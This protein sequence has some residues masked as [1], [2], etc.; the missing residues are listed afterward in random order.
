MANLQLWIHVP[1]FHASHFVTQQQLLLTVVN[2]KHKQRFPW[3]RH[4]D[5]RFRLVNTPSRAT[6][7]TYSCVPREIPLPDDATSLS[8]TVATTKS[9]AFPNSGR[10]LVP[11]HPKDSLF[12]TKKTNKLWNTKKREPTQSLWLLR[13]R[14]YEGIM[15]TLFHGLAALCQRSRSSKDFV[16]VARK[17]NRKMWF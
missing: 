6:K 8:L 15:K 9:S 14:D 4:Q 1:F 17:W 16:H 2:L 11:Y 7:N 5:F 3:S 13:K 12:H 10:D